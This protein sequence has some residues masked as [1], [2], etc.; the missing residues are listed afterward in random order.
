MDITPATTT[1][2]G[3]DKTQIS[4]LN[5]LGLGVENPDPN[6]LLQPEGAFHVVEI[7]NLLWLIYWDNL[8]MLLEEHP[9]L[10]RYFYKLVPSL[11]N[12][13]PVTNILNFQE[14]SEEAEDWFDIFHFE[15]Q[16]LKTAYELFLETGVF[17]QIDD[18]RIMFNPILLSPRVKNDEDALKGQKS[19]PS[20]PTLITY[21]YSIFHSSNSSVCTLIK[22]HLLQIESSVN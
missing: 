22:K 9:Q 12:L 5:L 1:T 21:F 15:D 11:N 19:D 16:N 4:F 14:C 7:D 8:E 10:I 18:Q 6:D 13:C 20:L 2:S 17:V 3:T